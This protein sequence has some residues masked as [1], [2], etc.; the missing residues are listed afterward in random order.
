[1]LFGFSSWRMS[2]SARTSSSLTSFFSSK[3]VMAEGFELNPNLQNICEIC[4][5]EKEKE[6]TRVFCL[7]LFHK[8]KTCC[9]CCLHLIG[10]MSIR[11]CLYFGFLFFFFKDW[12]R[13]AWYRQP[14]YV[15]T[16]AFHVSSEQKKKELFC[17]SLE[18]P[19]CLI[20]DLI[21]SLWIHESLI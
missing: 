15:S 8:W 16:M 1:M 4:K 13:Y 2:G 17:T 21:I 12:E 10:G 19:L 14:R 20:T 3:V 6:N 7:R 5:K 9:L 11:Y 18:K